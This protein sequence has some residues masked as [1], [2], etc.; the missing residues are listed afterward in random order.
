MSRLQP[1]SPIAGSGAT[2]SATQTSST[3]INDLGNVVEVHNSGANEVFVR[4]GPGAQTAVTTDF[5]LANGERRTFSKAQNPAS[6][7]EIGTI[8]NS[9]ETATVYIATGHGE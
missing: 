1:L 4:I 8:C 9:G 7:W 5:P 6:S 3:A 2:I